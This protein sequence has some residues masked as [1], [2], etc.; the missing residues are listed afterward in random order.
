MIQLAR[1]SITHFRVLSLS[2]AQLQSL[3]ILRLNNN[4]IT[5]LSP[6]IFELNGLEELDLS[7]NQL[8]R[9]PPGISKLKR[10]DN[11]KLRDNQLESIPQELAH[12]ADLYTLDISNNRLVTL[13][14]E[15]HQQPQLTRFWFENNLFNDPPLD[16]YYD[17]N[18]TNATN[19]ATN[20]ADTTILNDWRCPN[21]LR[22]FQTT[23]D[24]YDDTTV[25]NMMTTTNDSIASAFSATDIVLDLLMSNDTAHH[26]WWPGLSVSFDSHLLVRQKRKLISYE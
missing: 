1:Q 13:P 2:L 3:R 12:L 6:S 24:P 25:S 21:W 7:N 10:L 22:Q 8:R 14:A 19:D 4:C 18:N 15:L 5:E 23:V 20:D 17:R 16:N 26:G 9:L 11:L